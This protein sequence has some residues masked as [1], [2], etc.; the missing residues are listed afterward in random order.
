MAPG[1]NTRPTALVFSIWDVTAVRSAER[2]NGLDASCQGWPSARRASTSGRRSAS[3]PRMR[4]EATTML[5]ME[6]P[7]IIPAMGTTA[8]PTT[9]YMP[10][11]NTTNRLSAADADVAPRVR[12]MIPGTSGARRRT[13]NDA[14]SSMSTTHTQAQTMGVSSSTM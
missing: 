7:I 2:T 4:R 8:R 5:P 11:P 3:S 13:V 9:G 12:R 10:S 14:T 6:L 1:R